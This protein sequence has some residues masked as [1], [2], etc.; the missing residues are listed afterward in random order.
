MAKTISAAFNEFYGKLLPTSGESNAAIRHRAS[1]KSCL[2]NEFPIDYFFRTGSFG[3]GTNIKAYSD[4]D[5][6]AGIKSSNINC[7]SSTLLKKFRDVLKTRFSSTDIRISSPG[8]FIPF[9]SDASEATEVIPAKF[10]KTDNFE[11]ADGNDG[12]M[13]SCPDAHNN[14]VSNINNK[15]NNKVKPLIRFLKAWKY[16]QD[17]PILSFY[18]E[19]RVAKYSSEENYI[20]YSSDIFGIISILYNNNLADMQDPMGISGYISP[21]TTINKKNEAL[22]KLTT[23]FSRAQKAIEAEK[24]GKIKDAFDWWSLFFGENFPTYG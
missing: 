12:W 22:S 16:Y 8:V 14:Y 6:F 1:I 13:K 20:E 9:G 7:N 21:C 11:I 18:L 15:L 2:E 23:A 17:V 19:L 3:N 4:V 10:I 24:T 5:Y